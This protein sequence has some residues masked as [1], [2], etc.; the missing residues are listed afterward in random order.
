MKIL[1][2]IMLTLF[3]SLAITSCKSDDDAGPE[4]TGGSGSFTAKVNGNDFSGLDG[5]VVAREVDSGPIKTLA[6]SGGTSASENLQ[7]IIQDFDGVGTYD[8]GLLNIGTYSYLPDPAN[9]DPNTV[10]IYTTVTGA[11][12]QIN[13]SSYDGTTVSGTLSFTGV[14]LNNASDTVS[15]TDGEFN[16]SITRQ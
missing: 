3:V 11:G 1:K 12:G 14:N 13:V 7:I 4:A 10:V 8:L 16:I 2:T 15:I 5:T 9:P 6:V